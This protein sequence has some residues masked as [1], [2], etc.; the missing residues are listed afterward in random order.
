MEQVEVMSG[1]W[2]QGHGLAKAVAARNGIRTSCLLW[3]ILGFLG[4]LPIS[5]VRV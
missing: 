3:V 5:K 4:H 1:A 2:E